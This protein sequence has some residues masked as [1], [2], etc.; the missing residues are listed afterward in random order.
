M[1]NDTWQRCCKV[2]TNGN[3]RICILEKST[4]KTYKC[5]IV[6]F[7]DKH[8]WV[9]YR[10][11]A[12]I[13]R[14]R[15]QGVM[16]LVLP[17]C[18]FVWVCGTYVVHQC[19]GTELCCAPLTCVVHTTNGQ[20]SYNTMCVMNWRHV[21]GRSFFFYFYVYWLRWFSKNHHNLLK[22]CPKFWNIMYLTKQSSFAL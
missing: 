9:C 11:F 18:Q 12:H 10:L 17:V 19:N 8:D 7:N 21:S 20:I 13:Y 4:A 3:S 2:D 14:P 22:V 16:C 5:T 1:I 15:R 6:F